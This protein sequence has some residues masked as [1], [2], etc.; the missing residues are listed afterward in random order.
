MYQL[1]PSGGQWLI[2]INYYQLLPSGGSE[3]E[4][5]TDDDWGTTLQVQIGWAL[6]HQI[7]NE[8]QI[9]NDCE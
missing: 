9:E 6:K 5:Q 8:K 1:L 7:R 2:I 3:R 4:H